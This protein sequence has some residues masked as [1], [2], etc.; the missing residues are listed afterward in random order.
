VSNMSVSLRWAMEGLAE[1]ALHFR[2]IMYGWNYTGAGCSWLP[3]GEQTRRSEEAR[4]APEEATGD[5]GITV[6]DG[7]L[8]PTSR[9]AADE[10]ITSG[11]SAHRT[12]VSRRKTHRPSVPPP[13]AGDHEGAY[14]PYNRAS[15][16]SH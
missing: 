10:Q 6:A 13:I 4:L 2:G 8:K 3:S 15:S 5:E 7:P 11:R 1:R 14:A 9:G 16:L 12:R